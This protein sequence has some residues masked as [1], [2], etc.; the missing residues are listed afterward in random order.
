LQYPLARARAE[1]PLWDAQ[2][3]QGVLFLELASIRGKP[4]SARSAEV[5]K[6]GEMRVGRDAE[7]SM[8]VNLTLAFARLPHGL[9]LEQQIA[10][11]VEAR[12]ERSASKGKSRKSK[13]R[14]APP[15]SEAR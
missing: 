7:V 1:F 11:R 3:R 13:L 9:V 8:I 2:G 15:R 4:F 12:I 5:H 14:M 10:D 6:G